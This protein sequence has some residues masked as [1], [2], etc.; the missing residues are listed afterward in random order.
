MVFGRRSHREFLAVVILQDRGA[1]KQSSD[2][3]FAGPCTAWTTALESVCKDRRSRA[4]LNVIMSCRSLRIRLNDQFSAHHPAGGISLLLRTKCLSH[5]SRKKHR[6]CQRCVSSCTV[7]CAVT[8]SVVCLRG[9]VYRSRRRARAA[10]HINVS[11]MPSSL[12]SFPETK[13]LSIIGG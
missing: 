10:I 3:L 1:N 12:F 7:S 13:A 8:Y 11:P 2:L 5:T 6:Y 4:A 9:T